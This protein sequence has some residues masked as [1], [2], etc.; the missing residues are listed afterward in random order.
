MINERAINHAH[1]FGAGTLFLTERPKRTSERVRYPSR[2]FNELPMHRPPRRECN[3]RGKS[4]IR[5]NARES[6][7]SLPSPPLPIDWISDDSESLVQ[8]TN[9]EEAIDEKRPAN[10][11][12]TTGKITASRSRQQQAR[13]RT[14]ST[15][16]KPTFVPSLSLGVQSFSIRRVFR[17]LRNFQI[18]RNW[19]EPIFVSTATR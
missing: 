15:K 19:C 14:R 4:L 16:A 13:R 9:R 11:R 5:A 8:A 6:A 1:L 2:F 10:K 7:R 12:D 18:L 3:F 17:I